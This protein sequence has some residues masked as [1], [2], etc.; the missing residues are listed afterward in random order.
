MSSVGL[1]IILVMY[2]ALLFFIAH[3]AE[4]K[5]NSKWTNNK[6]IYSLSL[7]VYCTAWT[8]YG[9]IGVAADSGLSYLS[10]YIGPIIIIPAW[11]LI[12]KKIIKIFK[13]RKKNSNFKLQ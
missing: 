10:V 9:S 11:I 6:Y 3:W 13:K 5:R 2:L 12:L 7:A 1:L 4:K 8:Y